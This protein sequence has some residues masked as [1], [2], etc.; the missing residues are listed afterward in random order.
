MEPGFSPDTVKLLE[1]RGH[2][3]KPVHSQGEVCAILFDKGWL[4]GA[5]DPRVEAV[6]QGY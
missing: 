5:A 1:A 6:A 2:R 4:Q 3:P